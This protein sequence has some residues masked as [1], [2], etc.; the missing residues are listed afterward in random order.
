MQLVAYSDGGNKNKIKKKSC[1]LK[2]TTQKLKGLLRA[3]DLSKPSTFVQQRKSTPAGFTHSAV[4]I[5][6]SPQRIRLHKWLIYL[7][8]GSRKV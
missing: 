5:S 8:F 2:L 3:V 1:E 4:W 7:V 6:F